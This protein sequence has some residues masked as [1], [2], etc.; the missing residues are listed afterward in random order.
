[1]NIRF[2]S[3]SVVASMHHRT[4]RTGTTRHFSGTRFSAGGGD[5]DGDGLAMVVLVSGMVCSSVEA[6]G[7]TELA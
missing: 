7:R 2:D 5:V 4:R 1:M 3:K 6:G